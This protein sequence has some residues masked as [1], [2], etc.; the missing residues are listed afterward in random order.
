MIKKLIFFSLILYFSTLIQTSLLVHFFWAFPNIVL[1]IIILINLF[2][3][4]NDY[5]GLI[6]A[7]EGGF[8]LDIFS[9]KFFGIWISISIALSVFIKFILKRYVQTPVIKKF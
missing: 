3:K 7:F 5:L 2:E 4:E 6:L 9:G 1:I 8:F